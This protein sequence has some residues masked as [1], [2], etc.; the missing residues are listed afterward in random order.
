MRAIF[1]DG[2]SSA[3][4]S[5]IGKTFNNA[6]KTRFHCLETLVYLSSFTKS[7]ICVLSLADVTIAPKTTSPYERVG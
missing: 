4:I 3:T 6:G 7:M 1:V 5:E 2:D